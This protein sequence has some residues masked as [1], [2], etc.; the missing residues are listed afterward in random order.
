MDAT[1]LRSIRE[2]VNSGQLVT[3]DFETIKNF[4]KEGPRQ[5]HAG[6]LNFRE[7]MIDLIFSQ[8]SDVSPTNSIKSKGFLHL[9]PKNM[10]QDF[11]VSICEFYSGLKGTGNVKEIPLSMLPKKALLFFKN[12]LKYEEVKTMNQNIYLESMSIG[13]PDTISVSYSV[14]FA[15]LLLRYAMTEEIVF[16]EIRGRQFIDSWTTSHSYLAVLNQC[17]QKEFL[18]LRCKDSS[19]ECGSCD[20]FLSLLLDYWLDVSS[21]VRKNPEVAFHRSMFL[22]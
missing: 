5:Q 19:N 14:Y 13:S 11:A 8:K 7:S 10:S 18:S 17:I 9:V 12:R 20:I 22:D 3:I 1:K 21:I 16:E 15:I 6:H 4:L 2:R